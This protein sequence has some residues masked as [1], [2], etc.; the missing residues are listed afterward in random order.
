MIGA[1]FGIGFV[2]GP[3]LGGVLGDIDPHLPFWGAA[4]L[5]LVNATYGLF[6]LPEPLLPEKRDRFSWAKAN[7]VGSLKLLRSHPDLLG[8]ASVNL[9]FQLAHCCWCWRCW[10]L[11]GPLGRMRGRLGRLLEPRAT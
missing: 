1:A 2:L 5:D 4:G 3:A 11:S 8:L 10:W 6:V 9:L 7:P